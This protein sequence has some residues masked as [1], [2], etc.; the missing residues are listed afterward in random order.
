MLPECNK[1][2]QKRAFALDKF[3]VLRKR[4][5]TKKSIKK[6]KKKKNKKIKGN[7]IFNIRLRRSYKFTNESST[8]SIR[9]VGKSTN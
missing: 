9:K 6:K 5:L 8:K 3:R 1:C 4:G 2:M 7:V